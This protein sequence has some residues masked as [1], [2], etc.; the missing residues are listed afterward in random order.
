MRYVYAPSP[1][2]IY[3][4]LMKA[5]EDVKRGLDVLYEVETGTITGNDIVGK[6]A[7]KIN[8]FNCNNTCD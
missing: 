6:F 8:L 4:K 3:L 5:F 7:A 2:F 1:I